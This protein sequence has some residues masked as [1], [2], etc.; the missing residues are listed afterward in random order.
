MQNGGSV[1]EAK[2]IKSLE[3]LLQ[4]S[5]EDV[6]PKLMGKPMASVVHQKGKN[7]PKTLVCHDMR[8]NYLEDRYN[9][10]QY[11]DLSGRQVGVSKDES[12]SSGVM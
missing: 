4:W 1:L 2:P 8:G 11:S 10:R 6:H 3:D 9:Q 5:L 12:V 7:Q